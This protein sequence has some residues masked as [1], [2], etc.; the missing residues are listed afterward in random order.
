MARKTV[1]NNITSPELLKQVNEENKY[2]MKEFLEY[3]QS[4][5]RA[6]TT[7]YQYEQDLNIFWAWNLTH[8]NNKE[9]IKI[10]KREFAKF[11]NHA[12]NE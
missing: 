8:N 7:I 1:Y 12:I 10:T 6:K 2:L 9:F 3:L 11:Q 5:D 4:I